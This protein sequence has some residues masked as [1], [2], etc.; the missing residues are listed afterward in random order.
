VTLTIIGFLIGA[1]L[2]LRFNVLILFPSIGLALLGTTAVGIAHGDPMGSVVLTMALIGT[3][4]QVG[5]LAG[6]LAR[7]VVASVGV[8]NPDV[9]TPRS[10]S[11][12][13]A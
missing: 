3:T 1:A 9:Q 2:A 10:I 11:S 7:A 12:G 8:P 4:L 6:I 5:Y 13:A